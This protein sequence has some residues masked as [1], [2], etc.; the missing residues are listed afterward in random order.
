MQET[1]R[2]ATGLVTIGEAQ[3][4]RLFFKGAEHGEKRSCLKRE[5]REELKKGNDPAKENN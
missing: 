1:W 2:G 3:T 4:K 5:G